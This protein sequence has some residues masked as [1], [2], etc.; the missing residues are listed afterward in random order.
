MAIFFSTLTASPAQNG[1]EF[2]PSPNLSLA[3]SHGA[4]K[5][6][7]AS[8]HAEKRL[9]D[10]NESA[11]N[12]RCVACHGSMTDDAAK[13]KALINP[14]QSHLGAVACTTCHHG[15]TASQAYCQQCH[16]VALAIPG[17]TAVEARNT[18]GQLSFQNQTKES[19]PQ[20]VDV[21]IIGS[22]AAGFAAAITAHDLGATVVILE[23]QPITGGNSLLAAGGMNAA[24]T[25][26]QEERGIK[27]S[28]ELMYQDTLKGGKTLSDPDLV[29]I[30]AI[31]S[32]SAI[33]WLTGLGADLSEVGRL[34]GASVDRAHRPRGGAS[35]GTHLIS[36]LRKNALDRGID[37]RVNTRVV[38]L[39]MDK[40]GRVSG[41][42]VYG[43]HRGLY[44]ITARAVIDAAGGFSANPVKVAFY[45]PELADM[46]TTNQPGATGDGIDLG[47]IV[48][49]V[50]LDMKEIQLHPTIAATGRTMIT[51]A[52]RG[53]GAILVNREGK[54]FVNEL[55]TRDAVTAAVL[56][57]PGKSAFLVFDEGV[58]KSLRQIEGYF[59]LG[60][61]K[62]GDTPNEL[63]A[64]LAVSATA[65]E[66]T[67]ASYNKAYDAKKDADFRRPDLPRPLRSPKYYAVEVRP[68]IH[69]TMGGLKINR[70]AQV[71]GKDGKP[72][73]HFYAAGEVTGGVHGANRLGGNAL[74]EAITFG[75]I[76]GENAAKQAKEQ[77]PRKRQIR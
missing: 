66:A 53:N 35:I 36:V 73:P 60:L 29:K 67:L 17:G 44:T 45:R 69:Y 30:L 5:I 8:C 25:T 77:L 16:N 51:E 74:S 11:L 20:N 3:D 9:L 49:G 6:G 72:V 4:K 1:Q 63:G 18:T 19:K 68:G 10:D 47:A 61:V 62:E 75:R 15:H 27:D 7:C 32:A 39:L 26:Y 50:V 65:L 64:R 58:R 71:L 2:S 14:H 23:K 31:K 33:D 13:T 52:I 37:V 59:S 76:A 57:Q 54:R 46:A 41:V 40:Q 48:G 42:R 55:D 43:K 24:G 21:A 34:A 38:D 12:P 70:E 28:A 22:G 56:A